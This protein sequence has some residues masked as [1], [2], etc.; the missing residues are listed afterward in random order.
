MLEGLTLKVTILGSGTSTGVPVIG[1]P[2][3]VCCSPLAFNQRSRSSLLL[4]RL[5]TAENLVIDTSPDFRWQILQA[6]VQSLEH[7]LY[8]H[9]HADHCHGFDDLRA[10]YFHSR[11]PVHCYLG[12]EDLKDLRRRFSYAFHDSGYL[13]TAP[14]VE[15]H[16]IT[17]EKS[18]EAMGLRIEPLLLP[19]GSVSTTAF[20]FG[21]FA[22]A[23]DF[24]SFPPEALARW[25]GKVKTMVASGLRFRPHQT[26]SSIDETIALFNQLGVEKGI[27]T[28]LSHEVDYKR[29]S[30][31]LPRHVAFAYD[32]LTFE[33]TA[34]SC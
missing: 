24:K 3:E 31:R 26:H 34:S 19:H 21:S 30:K 27:I 17:H 33:V 14:Q 4:T 11:K 10:F 28:H 13:G 32:G 7:V 8:T 20:R 6:K 15:T 23:T 22:Y 2:C 25:K 18:F 5:D 12:H 29:D 1:C 16:A 9:T